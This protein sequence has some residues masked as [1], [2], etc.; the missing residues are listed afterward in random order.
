[1]AALLDEQ[2]AGRILSI[3]GPKTLTF[4]QAT[5]II[6][7]AIGKALVY[8]TISDEEA[9]DRYS[10][11]SGSPEETAA[12]VAL[13]RAIREGRVAATTD[14]VKQILAREPISLDQWASENA[15]HFLL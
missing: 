12:H 7:Q 11:V 10:R 14:Q 8:Q 2:Y 4:G 5:Q 6:G 13:W 9:G 1:M 15:H 3:T